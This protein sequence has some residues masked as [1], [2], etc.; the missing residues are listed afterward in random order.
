MIY[1]IVFIL[2]I[3]ALFLLSRKLNIKVYSA[4]RKLVRNK[5]LSRYIFSIIFFPGTFV[6][7][8][9][10][11]LTALLTGVRTGDVRLLPVVDEDEFKLGSVAIA[12]TDPVRRF[13]I[14]VAPVFVGIAMIIFVVSTMLAKDLLSSWFWVIIT[15][16]FL[17][18]VGNTMFSSKKDMEGS[19]RVL[20]LLLLAWIV[21]WYFEINIPILDVLERSSST[22]ERISLLMLAPIAV[23][24][25]ILSVFRTLEK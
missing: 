19:Y 12:K 24:I 20:I 1:F 7:E 6:H 11:F 16:Y 3:F 18:V 10:H 2:E 8:M 5:K 9:A 4:I 22:F 25:I 23:D 14:G 15:I 21:I 13:L 17:F